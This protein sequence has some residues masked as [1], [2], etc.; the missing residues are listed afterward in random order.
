MKKLEPVEEVKCP[1][2]GATQSDMG[3]NVACEEC[4]EGPMPSPSADRQ[5][6]KKKRSR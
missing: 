6:T 2:C 3:R 4:G 5:D 1:W